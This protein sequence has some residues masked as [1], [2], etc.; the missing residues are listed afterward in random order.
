[1]LNS[2]KL[3]LAMYIA[4]VVSL[5]GLYFSLVCGTAISNDSPEP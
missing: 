2:L 3:R 5:L 4:S 1:M